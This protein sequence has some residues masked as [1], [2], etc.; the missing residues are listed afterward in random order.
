MP[1][2]KK[3][4]EKR[5]EFAGLETVKCS[6]SWG[7]VSRRS[8]QAAPPQDTRHYQHIDEVVPSLG[9]LAF[10]R[11]L[12][13][14][15][16][17]SATPGGRHAAGGWRQSCPDTS[18]AGTGKGGGVSSGAYPLPTTHVPRR[19]QVNSWKNRSERLVT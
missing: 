19:N 3:G 1:G 2:R 10:A 7:G 18:R 13:P 8:P 14:Y 9:P 17:T 5:M 12:R 15:H 6:A 11:F 16:D 4:K